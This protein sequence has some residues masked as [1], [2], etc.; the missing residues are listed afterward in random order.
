VCQQSAKK[1]RNDQPKHFI[2]AYDAVLYYHG[3][4]AL[5][6]NNIF[7]VTFVQFVVNSNLK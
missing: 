1:T 7:S 3:N 5:R 2:A 6:Y 4:M